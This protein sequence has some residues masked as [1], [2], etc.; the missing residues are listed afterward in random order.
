MKVNNQGASPPPYTVLLTIAVIQGLALLALYQAYQYKVWP[1]QTPVFAYPL[2]A[3][4]VLL[5][6][7]LQL[8]LTHTNVRL[9]VQLSI[10]CS[11]LIALLA[12]YLGFQATP[13]NAFKTDALNVRGLLAGGVASFIALI[14]VQQLSSGTER[15]YGQLLLFSWR[16]LLM[17]IF[18]A[19]FV[20]LFFLMLLLWSALFAQ[21]GI[22]IFKD[23]FFEAW[24]LIPTLT[25]AFSVG[26][27]VFKEL[28]GIIDQIW[29]LVRALIRLLLPLI[30]T[31]SVLFSAS[32]PFTGL[33]VLWA[34]NLGTALLLAIAFVVLFYLNIVYQDGVSDHPYPEL[35]HRWITVSLPVVVI[36]SLLS[37]VGLFAR[38]DQY[39]W[40]VARFWAGFIWVFL[41]LFSVSYT[42]MVWKL[43]WRWPEGLS[44]CNTR[45]AVLMLA[46]LVLVNSPLLDFRKLSLASQMARLER[47]DV[48]LYTFD[49]FYVRQE[50]ARPG[51]LAIEQ[52]KASLGDDD[53]ELLA[54]I[55]SPARITNSSASA[56]WVYHPSGLVLP[57]ALVEAMTGSSLS[58]L[59]PEE[60]VSVF[61][62][63][64][65]MNEDGR[66]DYAFIPLEERELWRAAVY[67]ERSGAWHPKP[68][69]ANQV[70]N[71]NGDPRAWTAERIDDSVPRLRD[72]PFKDLVIGETVF[73]ANFEVDR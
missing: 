7:G 67:T 13:I 72:A 60:R 49:F 4:T 16:N 10:G 73:R 39:G 26:L 15:S 18:A 47:G 46:G 64:I 48:T 14:F 19:L 66:S 33:D 29:R 28:T 41:T 62:V 12:G 9:L 69:V 35:I 54:K 5:P 38:L 11:V 53:A 1:S 40:T 65:D 50:L 24:F 42:W 17:G 55:E 57:E 27:A 32:L 22:E 31:V 68:L 45:I 2:L 56:S 6:I 51:Y 3:V 59:S 70:V 52:L 30:L 34:T 37:L 43:R 44:A 58:P 71:E 61:V 21:I 63:K 20:G 8:A 36:L 23:V 25:I